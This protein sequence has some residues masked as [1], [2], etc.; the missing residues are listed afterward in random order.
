MWGKW[1]IPGDRG[2]LGCAEPKNPRNFGVKSGKRLLTSPKSWDFREK[3]GV[4]G[5]LSPKF[6]GFEGEKGDLGGFKAKIPGFG[7]GER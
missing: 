3:K 7:K 1:E 5:V 6:W 4:W 2:G